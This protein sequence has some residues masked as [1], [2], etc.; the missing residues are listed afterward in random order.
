MI[1]ELRKKSQITIPKEIIDSLSLQEGDHLEIKLN[2]GVIEIEP[3]AIYPKKYIE[4]LEKV[5]MQVKNNSNNSAGPF[6]SVDEAI[7]Y[8]E[9]KESIKK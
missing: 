7:N 8:L 4:R 9:D 3:V 2:H 5:V 6:K 1:I